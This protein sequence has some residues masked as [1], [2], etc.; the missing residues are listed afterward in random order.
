[1]QMVRGVVIV[2]KSSVV[3]R[4]ARGSLGEDGLKG[5]GTC[6]PPIVIGNKQFQFT[7]VTGFNSGDKGPAGLQKAERAILLESVRDKTN[8]SNIFRTVI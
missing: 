5:E 2:L 7:F 4:E 6:T 8:S 1:M 3:Y